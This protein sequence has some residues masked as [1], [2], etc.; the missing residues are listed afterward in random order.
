MPQKASPLPNEDTIKES[1]E[2]QD[3]GNGN[4]AS[5]LWRKMHL[6]FYFY[7]LL[8]AFAFLSPLIE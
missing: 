6:L 2:N 1:G 4:L 7:F 3:L 8:F 5:A